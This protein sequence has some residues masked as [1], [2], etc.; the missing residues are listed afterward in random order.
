LV[1]LPLYAFLIVMGPDF[2]TVLFTRQYAASWPIFAI[3]LTMLP[4]SVLVT[5]P[6][7]R[8][9]AEHRKF[10]PK[11]YTALVVL[12]FSLLWLGT[13]RFGLI[14]AISVVVGV[15]V[16]GRTAT[17]I[18]IGTI[19][20]IRLRDVVLLKDVGKL[21]I[22]AATAAIVV[23]F[24]RTVL[25]GSSPVSR[26]S[27]CAIVFGFFFLALILVLR[28]PTLEE[29]NYFRRQLYRLWRPLLKTVGE[30][31]TRS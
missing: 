25:H 7:M 1:Y 23:A 6:I 19:L 12:L 31:V 24:V 16:I 29:R 13:S 22:A 28:L 26:L 11:L 8:A 9:H 21:A 14:W 5:D 3:N 27:I 4:L 20:K 10:S 2:L 30:P 15:N 18:K 17:W